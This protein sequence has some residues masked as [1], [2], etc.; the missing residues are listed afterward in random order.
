MKQV[1][2]IIASVQKYI[3]CLFSHRQIM[4]KLVIRFRFAAS[5]SATPQKCDI[6]PQAVEIALK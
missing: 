2:N 5:H 4:A 1:I 6:F 3:T